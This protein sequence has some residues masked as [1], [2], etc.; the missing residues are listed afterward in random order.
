[1][2][3]GMEI[4]NQQFRKKV[5]GYDE[6]EVKS[7]LARIA[8][9][10]ENMYSENARLKENIQQ[11][12]YELEKYRKMEETMNNSLILAQQTAE[13]F[14]TNARHEAD[15]Y[16]KEAKQKITQILSVYQDVLKRLNIFNAELKAQLNGQIDL[17]GK[18]QQK[19]DELSDFFYG[20][21]FKEILEGMEKVAL[22]DEGNAQSV[23]I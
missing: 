7:F 8:V 18:N 14:K 12:Q 3:T 19:I 23:G 4:R 11:V 13:D 6:D 1:M 20:R 17:L 16:L 21:D 9:D 15:L 2:I 5:R 10:Y 22:K